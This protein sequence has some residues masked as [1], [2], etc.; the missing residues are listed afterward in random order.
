M[1]K[2]QDKGNDDYEDNDAEEDKE[3]DKEVEQKEVDELMADEDK[4][5]RLDWW[6]DP[7]EEDSVEIVFGPENKKPSVIEIN[8]D[9]KDNENEQATGRAKW[10]VY[11]LMYSR[12]GEQA[13]LAM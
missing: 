4:D 1:Y 3:Y 8:H 2:R 10:P 7:P 5:E 9:N 11:C 6:H 12:R 13:V